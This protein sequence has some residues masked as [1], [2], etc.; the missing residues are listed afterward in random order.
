MRNVMEVRLF[1]GTSVVLNAYKTDEPDGEI[2][3]S[4]TFL[5][6]AKSSNVI[7]RFGDCADPEEADMK[8]NTNAV[9]APHLLSFI[10]GLSV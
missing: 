7:A 10:V 8:H 4:D 6:A 5:T 9:V 1:V 2:C 3:G